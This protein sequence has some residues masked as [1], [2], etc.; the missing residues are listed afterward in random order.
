MYK[1][2]LIC[3][4]LFMLTACTYHQNDDLSRQLAYTCEDGGVYHIHTYQD[5]NNTPLLTLVLPNGQ[6]TTLVNVQAASGALYVG[7]IYKWWEHKDLVQMTIGSNEQ[8]C[9]PVK[10]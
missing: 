6:K 9:T 8:T 1:F 7:S 4:S 5:Q 10:K 3:F 2:L